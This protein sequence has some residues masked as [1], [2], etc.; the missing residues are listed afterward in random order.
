MWIETTTAARLSR[1]TLRVRSASSLDTGAFGSDQYIGDES[2]AQRMRVVEGRWTHRWTSAARA[3]ARVASRRWWTLS[4]DR[5]IERRH[6]DWGRCESGAWRTCGAR[7]GRRDT[8]R[9]RLPGA[10]LVSQRLSNSVPRS[11]SPRHSLRALA[12]GGSDFREKRLQDTTVHV[13]FVR[14]QP[15]VPSILVDRQGCGRGYGV[16]T[17]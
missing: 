13:D 3:R 16:Y 6:G 10:V 17:I 7:S 12:G 8:E 15:W 5:A 2:G 4:G 1:V 11:L 14:R 9:A